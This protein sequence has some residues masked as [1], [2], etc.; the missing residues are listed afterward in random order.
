[1]PRLLW[2]FKQ[3]VGP[4]PRVAH[5]SAFDTRRHR[6]ILFGGDSLS[7]GLFR[8]TWEWDGENWTQVADIGPPGRLDAAMVFDSRRTRAV[9]FGGID[10][11]QR[12]LSDTWEWD[13]DDWTQM[14]DTGPPARSG[15]AMAFDSSR[16]RVVL[17]GG[18]DEDTTFGDTWE[19]NGD[20]W[21]QVEDAGPGPRRF[22]AMT[23]DAARGRVVLFG[24]LSGPSAFGDTWE[25]DGNAWTQ[26]AD[27]GPPPCLGAS[28]HFA[29]RR[30]RLFGG[31]S[32]LTGTVAIFDRTW[33]WDGRHW[34]IRQD[35]GP[36][37]RR[38]HTM[39]FD[40]ARRRGVL[41]GGT[42]SQPGA[43][44]QV[45]SGETWEQFEEGAADAPQDPQPQERDVS[46]VV[47]DYFTGAPLDAVTLRVDGQPDLLSVSDADG[48]YVFPRVAAAESF[49]VIAARASHLETRNDVGPVG[50]APLVADLFLVTPADLASQATAVGEPQLPDNGAV[51]ID[52]VDD[53]GQP[54]EGLPATNVILDTQVL[55]A[56]A[57]AGPFFFGASG[58]LDP[59]IT[60]ATA[61]NGRSRAGFV[62][63]APVPWTLD[64]IP[65]G[66]PPPATKNLVVKGVTLTRR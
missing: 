27:F 10:G 2:T 1:M 42:A 35:L 29:G 49:V 40:A 8:D 48:K 51:F 38:G 25:F 45:A 47:R 53:A 6:A 26:I 32:G 37:P 52:L 61:F 63:V 18:A 57:P 33:E 44:S 54:R 55:A 56:P 12:A 66:Q 59:A 31:A 23:F 60:V 46:G 11:E 13:G 20:E 39:V 64:V 58:S 22:H 19:W 3:H 21:V 16:A 43:Q 7:D 15:H 9:L 4:R 34:T 30:S 24:G 65:V 14:A 50:S 28:L 41:F 36:G 62:N 17:F 5:A